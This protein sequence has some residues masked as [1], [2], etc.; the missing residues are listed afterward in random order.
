MRAQR[1]DDFLAH[2]AQWTG[3]LVLHRRY[4]QQ[5]KA[6]RPAHR[7]DQLT[8]LRGEDHVGHS[9][10]GRAGQL[11][12]ALPF[13]RGDGKAR[14]LRRLR[15]RLAA[16]HLRGDRL[17]ARFGRQHQLLDAARLAGGIGGLVLVVVGADVSIAG[18][19]RLRKARGVD[20]GV[21][22]AA[23]L[24]DGEARAVLLVEVDQLRVGRIL[25]VQESDGGDGR[26]IAL[27]C[28]QQ[29]RGVGQDQI[30][31]RAR[32]QADRR[33]QLALQDFAANIVAQRLLAQPFARQQGAE[34]VIAEIAGSILE[35]R[36]LRDLRVDQPLGDMHA[37]TIGKGPQRQ[38]LH[39]LV[40]YL[41]A[42]ALGE[43]FAD[44]K[45]GAG[46]PRIF[47]H[48]LHPILQFGDRQLIPLRLGRGAAAR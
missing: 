32:A 48:A 1:L 44:L 28:F 15:Q 26:N 6:E 40:E 37:L 36:D 8:L 46:A 45:L 41:R 31:R 19:G 30:F 42:A 34:T 3:G 12:A 22:D 7:T 38:R 47:E 4:A 5:Q 21:A 29:Q 20:H 2:R 23:L 10:A 14:R 24:G 13:Q 16:L 25:V 11:R 39:Q 35:G 9:L 33:E 17:G 43:E 18:R 27:P